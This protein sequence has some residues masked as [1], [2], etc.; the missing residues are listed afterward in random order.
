MTAK[1][2]VNDYTAL[3]ELSMRS[4]T[5]IAQPQSSKYQLGSAGLI[6]LLSSKGYQERRPKCAL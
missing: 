5:V 2:T 1:L 6:S 4:L 3:R